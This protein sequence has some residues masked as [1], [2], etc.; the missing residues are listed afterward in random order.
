MFIQIKTIYL[1]DGFC[2]M[3]DTYKPKQSNIVKLSEYLKKQKNGKR[4]IQ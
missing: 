2:N 4:N 3:K 1:M